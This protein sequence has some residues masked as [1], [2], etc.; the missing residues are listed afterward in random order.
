MTAGFLLQ[1]MGQGGGHWQRDTE[2]DAMYWWAS[3][4]GWGCTGMKLG[5]S[6][7]QRRALGLGCSSCLL[8]PQHSDNF[9][10]KFLS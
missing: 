9:H 6:R 7:V 3:R 5:G 10:S 1:G 2:E 8:L 4:A